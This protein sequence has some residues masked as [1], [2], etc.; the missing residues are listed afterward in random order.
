[1]RSAAV[2]RALPTLL[3]VGFAE[4]LAYRAQLLIWIL[5]TTMPFIMLVLW[6]AVAEE[7]PVG[8]FGQREFAA[9]FLATFVVRQLA[10]SWVAWE[11]NYEVR[12]GTL[13]MRLLRPIPPVVSYL[14]EAAAVVPM[15]VVACLPVVALALVLLGSGPLPRGPALLAA[16][17]C[18]LAGSWAITFLAGFAI[19]CLAFF[20]DS[21]VK[22]M[23]VWLALFYVF[24]GYLV[25]VELFP[26]WLGTLA[27]WLPF[28]Y[29]LGLPVELWTG[30]HA[31]PAALELL[32]RQWL[33]VAL[34]AA[35]AAA[36]WRAGV[37]R[38]A[39]YGG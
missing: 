3:R 35:L 33:Y 34:F 26:P 15:R 23:A 5:S 6:S 21:S 29:Q 4:G 18:A 24:S 1:V 16:A 37:R 2:V 12:H 28:R 19:G 9:Y 20:V 32:G 10:G 17:V 31:L 39:A 8:R 27:S 30:A 36:L 11:M 25:P 38:F 13:S 22:V 14:A 7:A